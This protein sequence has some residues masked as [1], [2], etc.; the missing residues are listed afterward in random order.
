MRLDNFLYELFSH[1]DIFR[2]V[3]KEDA[4]SSYQTFLDRNYPNKND[5]QDAWYYIHT[6]KMN[7]AE[8]IL[9]LS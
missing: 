1:L 6:L 4:V 2:I 5:K 7:G 9:I 3:S 8:S